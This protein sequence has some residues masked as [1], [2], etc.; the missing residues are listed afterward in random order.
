MIAFR[1]SQ[2][3]A[4]SCFGV[5]RMNSF[6][7]E[8]KTLVSSTIAQRL[9]VAVF[10]SI[11]VIEMAIFIPDYQREKGEIF[12]NLE[13]TAR[14]GAI[15]LLLHLE[16]HPVPTG[17]DLETLF[18]GTGFRGAALYSPSGK[19][20]KTMGPTPPFPARL[21]NA[22]K[23]LSIHD[24]EGQSLW[25]YWPES[26]TGFKQGIAVV[27]DTSHIGGL[28]Q[29]YFGRVSLRIFIICFFVT[30][31]AMAVIGFI[32]VFPLLHM[33]AQIQDIRDDSGLP[34]GLDPGDRNR[35]SELGELA[36]SFNALLQ[37]TKDNTAKLK[38]SEQRFKDF[39]ASAADR[40]WETDD[41]HRFTYVS[42]P[43]G[44][45][46][47]SADELVG[48]RQWEV[49][50][51]QIDPETESR[52]K[53]LYDAH[54]AFH[55]EQFS[56]RNS[57]GEM[58]HVIKSA[59]PVFDDDGIFMGFRGTTIDNSDEV[60]ARQTAEAANRVK[61]EFLANMSHEL[62]TPLN[63][64]LGF[65]EALDQKIFGELA[66]EKQAEYVRNIHESGHHL[67]DLINDILDVSAI[68][69][70]KLDLNETDFDLNETVEASLRLVTQR[71]YERGIGLLNRTLGKPL[72]VRMDERRLKQI[73][74]NLLSNAVKFTETGGTVSIYAEK[75]QNGSF[76]LTV[77]DTGIGMDADGI[78]K[79]LEKFGQVN[80]DSKL[81]QEG[82]G[83]GLPLAKG[84][85]E[86]HGGTLT[87]DSEPGTG[88]AVSLFFPKVCL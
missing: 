7:T 87:I 17:S 18:K 37:T 40:F 6:W 38:K 30:S 75:G 51:R 26:V 39:T 9:A 32:L 19:R 80:N 57:K 79:A 63:A 76:T 11:L 86:L 24:K 82:T 22:A 29:G 64:I 34:S 2:H 83:L 54:Q 84:L 42:S 28:L 1:K 43:H 67:L 10:A 5:S 55:G 27:R 8:L 21:D 52:L 49:G 33:H 20:L 31:V 71:A 60:N 16:H 58:R 23:P 13:E 88:T 70:G 12:A 15:S 41:Q 47:G 85:V 50:Y 46:S 69:A 65:S 53:T 59:I 48:K 68:E 77:S 81:D 14:T 36:N 78:G 44:G 61:T 56:W 35:N 73:L 62:R 45:L 4:E 25:L 74:V 72:R 3:L 66:N